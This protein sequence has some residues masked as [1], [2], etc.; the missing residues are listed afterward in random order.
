M[1][2]LEIMGVDFTK[3]AHSTPSTLNKKIFIY[4]KTLKKEFLFK[5]RMSFF[6]KISKK[7]FRVS[8]PIYSFRQ[9]KQ[10]W[11]SIPIYSIYSILYIVYIVIYTLKS[12]KEVML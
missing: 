4:S 3:H 10:L 8:I 5:E 1:T 2:K 11:V 12:K 7:L 9:S 6:E